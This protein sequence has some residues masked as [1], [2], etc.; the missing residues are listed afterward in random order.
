M[1]VEMSKETGY[2]LECLEMK[3]WTGVFVCLFL[4][5][6]THFDSVSVI[7][8]VMTGLSCVPTSHN[9]C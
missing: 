4:L 9:Q 6:F 1:T 5:G 2:P 8:I 3:W 7:Y